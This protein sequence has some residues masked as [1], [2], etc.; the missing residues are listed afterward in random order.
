MT[1]KKAKEKDF[2][3]RDAKDARGASVRENKK[4]NS[5]YFGNKR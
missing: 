4:T 2:N 1:E 5:Y 3:A